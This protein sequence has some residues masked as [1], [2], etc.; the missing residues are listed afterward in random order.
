M[1]QNKN[2][3]IKTKKKVLVFSVRRRLLGQKGLPESVH[4][5]PTLL[6][7]WVQKQA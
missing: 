3:Q 5:Q 4:S 6:C 1:G 7:V 2:Y